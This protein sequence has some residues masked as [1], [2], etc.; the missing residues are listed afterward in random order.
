MKMKSLNLA[1]LSISKK[2]A[3]AFGV[4]LLLTLVVMFTGL[5]STIRMVASGDDIS[6]LNQMELSVLD[7][8]VSVERFIATGTQE[9][10]T[11]LERLIVKMEDQLKQNLIY[12]RT[13]SEQQT[14]LEIQKALGAYRISLDE[15]V[16]A[17]NRRDAARARMVSSGNEALG[18]IEDLQKKGFGKLVD[19]K[20]NVELLQRVQQVSL[21]NQN[22]LNIRYLV[23]GYVFQQTDESDAVASKALNELMESLRKIVANAP[24]EEQTALNNAGVILGRYEAGY[25][26]FSQGVAESKAAAKK[27]TEYGSTMRSASSRLRQEQLTQRTAVVSAAK[28]SLVSTTAISIVLAI[29][30]AWVITAQI[31][32]PLRK[33][34]QVSSNIAKGDLRANL[35]SDRRDELGQLERSINDMAQN[36]RQLIGFIGDSTVRI[37]G[38]AEQLSVSTGQTNVGVTRQ[39]VETDQVATAMNEMANTVRGVARDAEEASVAASRADE[40]AKNGELKL[41]QV[42]QEMESLSD[43]VSLCATAI[44]TLQGECR[45]IGGVLTVIKSLA[46]QTNLLALNAAIEAARAGEAGTGFAVVADEVRALAQR[47]Q[48]AATEIDSL[49][50]TLLIGA[51]TATDFMSR[52]REMATKTLG[53]GRDAGD[54]LESI[55]RT[56]SV[57]QAMNLQIAAAAEEQ[58]VVAEQI[59]D[60]IYEV[61]AISEQTADA[62]EDTAASS[63]VLASLGG[64]LQKHVQ[65]FQI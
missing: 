15:L 61:R 21:L 25:H 27:L 13:P 26:L 3:L 38:A 46:E 52:S 4:V 48:K 37:T 22:L 36:L 56:I 44:N 40:E 24:R 60:S 30:A 8:Q 55:S 47:T 35:V 20:Q 54:S 50:G 23:R 5:R 58:S 45:Q 17:Q 63:T 43:E 59:N 65:R 34:L 1:H 64:E 31:V 29:L 19:E 12:L 16:Q 2:L 39:R 62:S 14:L 28:L 6:R 41:K 57:M 33:I 53:L 10:A 51:S 11:K 18:S 7:A 49:V 42:I 32:K 9:E